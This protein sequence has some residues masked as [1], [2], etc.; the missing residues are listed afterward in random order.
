M[1]DLMNLYQELIM[2]H[3]RHPRFHFKPEFFSFEEEGFN[4]FCG[5]KVH[6]YAQIR[7]Q[8]IEKLSFE[9]CGCAISMA[10]TSLMLENSQ[11]KSIHELK[12]LFKKFHDFMM[13]EI[14][15][16]DKKNLGKL[17]IFQGVKNYPT[18]VKCA[19]LPWHTL[20]SLLKKIH[21]EE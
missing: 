12:L 10:S 6:L 5:D 3:G 7:D 8:I 13:H 9:G 2:D 21:I 14:P 1:S 15:E 11:G 4:P 19:T 18:R 16:E 17:E 20:E